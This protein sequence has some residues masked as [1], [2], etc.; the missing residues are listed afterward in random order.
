MKFRIQV[1]DTIIVGFSVLSACLWAKTRPRASAWENQRMHSRKNNTEWS[2][3]LLGLLTST[4]KPMFSLLLRSMGPNGCEWLLLLCFEINVNFQQ[5][6]TTV[7]PVTPMAWDSDGG[8]GPLNNYFGNWLLKGKDLGVKWEEIK[9]GEASHGL[10]DSLR[11]KG[12]AGLGG[13]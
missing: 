11:S 9:K 2:T 13:F 12:S 6:S 3:C 10:L 1:L 5:F 4:K 8:M 7:H